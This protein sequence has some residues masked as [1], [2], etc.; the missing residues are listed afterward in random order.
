MI[1]TPET[2]NAEQPENA[3][4]MFSGEAPGYAEPPGTFLGTDK[5]GV[6]YFEHP[7]GYVY[8]WYP[9]DREYW[10]RGK[11]MQ[12]KCGGWI[13]RG[14]AWQRTFHKIIWVKPNGH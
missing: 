7:D 6:R 13:C 4:P 12:G 11:N 3:R 9:I 5:S 2:L 1:K 14:P 10:V 8:R